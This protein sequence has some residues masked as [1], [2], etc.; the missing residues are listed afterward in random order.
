M[1][2]PPAFRVGSAVYQCWPRDRRWAPSG[3]AHTRRQRRLMAPARALVSNRQR[4]IARLVGH[5]TRAKGAR[6]QSGVNTNGKHRQDAIVVH[7][8]RA[9]MRHAEYAGDGSPWYSRC[10]PSG[11]RGK[12]SSNSL[13]STCADRARAKS[14]CCA[15]RAEFNE[16]IKWRQEGIYVTTRGQNAKLREERMF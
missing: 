10:A 5:N 4:R 15:A 8:I 1:S 9:S 12:R 7:M 6:L 13:R 14:C 3:A 2:G 11:R 16:A